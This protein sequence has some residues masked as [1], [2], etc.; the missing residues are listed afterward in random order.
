VNDELEPVPVPVPVEPV[1]AADA[2][3]AVDAIADLADPIRR[4]LYRLVAAA[5]EPV[6]KDDAAAHLGIGRSLAA[7]HLDRLVAGGLLSVTY[8]RRHGRSGPGAGR[9]AK[10]YTA[11]DT[12]FRVALPPRD[13]VLLAPPS[14][15]TRRAQPAARSNGWRAP[16][17]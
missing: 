17:E 6:G 11:S 2:D 13:D 7:Y 10:L 15:R 8:A 12:E 14:R 3:E 5:A 16:R 1:G 9:P 4:A